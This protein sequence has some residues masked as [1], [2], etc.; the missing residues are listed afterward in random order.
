MFSVSIIL[1]SAQVDPS[2]A[3][4]LPALT[5]VDYMSSFKSNKP[6]KAAGDNLKHNHTVDKVEHATL[7]PETFL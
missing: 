2:I 7:W 4:G 3:S 5:E 1:E 6:T